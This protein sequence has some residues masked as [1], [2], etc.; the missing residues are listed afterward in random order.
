MSARLAATEQ[1]YQDDKAAGRTISLLDEPA[2]FKGGYKHFKIIDNRYPYDGIFKTHHMLVCK[3]PGANPSNFTAEEQR[4]L[5]AIEFA[6]FYK[7]SCV[8]T[9]YRAK[10]ITDIWHVHLANYLDERPAWLA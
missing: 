5:A 9:N 3:R 10:S 2:I 8:I 6:E 7:Y 1:R 4:E